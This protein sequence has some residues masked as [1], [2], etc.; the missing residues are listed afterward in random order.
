MY[1]FVRKYA[2]IP[3]QLKIFILQY[4]GRWVL[5]DLLLLLLL[6]LLLSLLVV[7]VCFN[8]FLFYVSAAETVELFLS[9]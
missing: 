5:M 3:V 1:C 6:L 9:L 4:I 2:A 7:L 8:C